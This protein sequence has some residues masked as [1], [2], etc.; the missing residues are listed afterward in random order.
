MSIEN[1]ASD[2]PSRV[3]GVRRRTL[4][5]SAAAAT[6]AGVGVRPEAAG[7]AA[8][9]YVPAFQAMVAGDPDV[10]QHNVSGTRYWYRPRQL[11]VA[12]ADATRVLSRLTADGRLGFVDGG[13]AGVTRLRFPA[14]VEIPS[15]V[16]DLRNPARWPGASVPVV[17]P[18]HVVFGNP[19]VMG[20]PTGPPSA[21]PP[22][23]APAAGTL[24]DGAGIRVGICD[25]GIWAAAG[26]RHPVWFAGSYVAK[27][28]DLDPVYAAGNTLALQGGH[29]TFVAGVLRQ[30]APGVQFDPS[31]ALS[32]AGVG[33]EQSVATALAGLHPSVALVNLSL[34]CFTHRDVPSLPMANALAA[35]PSGAVVV[36]SA[37]NSGVTRPTWPAAFPGVVA[38]AALDLT[39]VPATYSNSGP[40][41]D[42]CAI[43]D[44][45]A[46][47][48][49]GN[50][51]P[52]GQ[53]AETIAGFA[54]WAGTSFA[55]PYVA[56]RI[57]T[58]MTTTGVDARSAVSTL[59]AGPR[60]F[61][62]FGAIVG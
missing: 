45:T 22:V 61:A 29:G 52:P 10:R 20:N 27:N 32:P 28:T 57:A 46:P 9:W 17:Q 25:T 51:V 60:P 37:G 55:A 43:G 58:L 21:A 62:G 2:R 18:H 42:L 35:V 30:A 31:V 59:L 23:A 1:P 13:F 16:D 39:S 47:Y 40:W 15:L 49:A 19:N 33:D 4:L 5:M 41:V 24:G 44:R 50:V 48:V 14:E 8:P 6:V 11:L 3:P 53:P 7:A 38:V 34:G 36:A 54:R 12:P 56:G 26:Q